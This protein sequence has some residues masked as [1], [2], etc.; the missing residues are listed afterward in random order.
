MKGAILRLVDKDPWRPI[1]RGRSSRQVLL[2]EILLRYSNRRLELIRWQPKGTEGAKF[3][4]CFQTYLESD[5]KDH[6]FDAVMMLASR[7]KDSYLKW[8][9]GKKHYD[10]QA[11]A[12][13]FYDR[14]AMD[15]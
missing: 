13:P 15:T 12:F 4:S 5:K 6:L 9:F 10:S 14:V 11:Y 2:K 1:V 7:G 3:W 8:V